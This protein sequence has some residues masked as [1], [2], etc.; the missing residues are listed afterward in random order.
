MAIKVG[1]DG[2]D[3][4]IGT[5]GNDTLRGGDGN[6][7]LI[8]DSGSDTINAGNGDN[9][10]RT[11]GA[12]TD[13]AENDRFD[14]IL[15]GISE[16]VKI[17]E[18]T[19]GKDTLTGGRKDDLIFGQEGKDVIKGKK[20]DD[21]LS[22]GAGNDTLVGGN[23]KDTFA[24]TL[25]EGIDTVK[26]F[27]GK[28]RILIEDAFGSATSTDQFTYDNDTG[29]LFFDASVEGTKPVQ[30][31]TLPVNLGSTFNAEEDIVFDEMGIVNS[32]NSES[33][34]NISSAREAFMDDVLAD[35]GI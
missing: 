24:L 14:N 22:G 7:T 34:D 10:I 25:D 35:L 1:T 2:D 17:R 3:K 9:V 13:G 6:D 33:K 4:I 27:S 12:G 23:G 15:T 8:G 32:M 5:N 19:D 21:I 16:D 18:G 28:D 31:A 26:D 20:G 29:E 30:I 11:D